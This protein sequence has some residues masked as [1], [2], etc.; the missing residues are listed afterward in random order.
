MTCRY[1]K[2]RLASLALLLIMGGC[3]NYQALQDDADFQ[4]AYSS[5]S[6]SHPDSDLSPQQV[7][8]QAVFRRYQGTPYHYGGTSAR[9]FDCSGFIMTAY[10]EAFDQGLP[11]TTSQMLVYGQP[12]RREHLQPGDV[13]FFR[14]RGKE[15]HAG[16]YMGNER[17]IH[18]STS[19]GVIESSLNSAY[20]RKRYSQGRR[21][22]EPAPYASAHTH[23]Y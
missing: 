2:W 18:A 11:R 23:T 5:T 6:K 4:G 13:V 1:Q 12:V 22:T 10:R 19:R 20:W 15:Q 21:F 3:A 7:E 17:F 14:I 9:G 16:I 8:L